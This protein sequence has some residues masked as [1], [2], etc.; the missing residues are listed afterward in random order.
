MKTS[1]IHHVAI[2]CSDYQKPK[3]FYTKLVFQ[4][5]NQTFRSV[6]NSHKLDLKVGNTQVKLSSPT[7]P[8]QRFSNPEACRLRHLAFGVED[9]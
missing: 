4:T 9:I 3:H 6:R 7:D 5:I 1:S 8:Q 2:I